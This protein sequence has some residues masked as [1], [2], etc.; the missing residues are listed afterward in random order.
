MP[1]A[2]ALILKSAVP[3]LTSISILS[4]PP[5]P[6]LSA[7]RDQIVDDVW[8]DQ[9]EQI[10]PILRL[11]R[12]TEQLAQNRQVYKERNSGLR[13]RDLSHRKSA[14]Y[15]RFPVTDQDLVIGLLRLEG[16]SNVH[17]RRTH[18]RAFGMH[19]HQDLPGA[20]DVRRDAQVD[21]GLLELHRRARHVGAG[22]AGAH[23]AHVDD[24][25]RHA[26]A[27]ED[28][29]LAVVERGDRGL[30]LD[31]GE[32]DVAQRLHECRQIEVPDR[33]R[34]DQVERR[35]DD[36]LAGVAER[37]ERVPAERDD[38]LVRGEVFRRHERV[39]YAVEIGV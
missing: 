28:L 13:Y 8:R 25:D 31:V 6:L 17:R 9:N 21:T 19:L 4:A 15:G 24:T 36:F 39:G 34:E 3:R 33:G 29:G 11:R 23:G 14:N 7:G 32:L 12:K 37:G 5:W 38:V 26:I 22:A 27:D 1:S 30:S 20:G 2:S 16:E 18:A 35:V 10:T